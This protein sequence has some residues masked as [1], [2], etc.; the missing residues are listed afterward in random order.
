MILPHRLDPPQRPQMGLI[1]LQSDETIERDM[2]RLIPTDATLYVTRVPS[3]AHVSSETLAAMRRHLSTAAGLFP[4]TAAFSV[5]G[6]GCTSASA[7]IGSAEVAATIRRGCETGAVTEPLTATLAACLA[8]NVRR[9]AMLSPYL[10]SVSDRLVASLEA[11][12]VEVTGVASFEQSE[13]HAVACIDAASILAGA[14][15]LASNTRADA[16]FLSCTNLRTLSAIDTIEAETGLAVLSSNQ[17][18]A[19]DMLRHAG[20]V[21]AKGPGKLWSAKS[22]LLRSPKH[23]LAE[24][25]PA[26]RRW[27]RS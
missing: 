19:W 23:S 18:L 3:A 20:I 25:R 6:Y 22:S 27:P 10:P 12:G 11:G 4:Q 15:A 24:G 5:V 8:L 13:E 1:V 26:G 16:L 21:V 2:R 17:V 14:Q 7:E 9:I